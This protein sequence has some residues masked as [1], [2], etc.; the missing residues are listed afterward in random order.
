MAELITTA[1]FAALAGVRPSTVAYWRKRY[2]EDFPAE[3]DR[4]DAAHHRSVHYERSAVE[5][6]LARHGLRLEDAE[7]MPTRP[8]RRRVAVVETDPDLPR[9][10]DEDRFRHGAAA[11]ASTRFTVLLDI[12][13][14]IALADPTD[15]RERA[16]LASIARDAGDLRAK[17]PAE[18][19]DRSQQGAAV[20]EALDDLARLV[21]RHE[22]ASVRELL[23]NPGRWLQDAGTLIEIPV[24]RGPLNRM[25]AHATDPTAAARYFEQTCRSF[26]RSPSP[27]SRRP[28]DVA[29]ALTKL[30]PHLAPERPRTFVDLTCGIGAAAITAYRGGSKVLGF[31]RNVDDVRV[32][33]Q[34]AIIVERFGE[35]HGPSAVFEGREQLTE[36][37]FRPSDMVVLS[38]PSSDFGL[39][40]RRND[41]IDWDGLSRRVAFARRQLT[42]GGRV[43]LVLPTHLLDPGAVRGPDAELAEMARAEWVDGLEAVLEVPPLEMAL[44]TSILIFHP[45]GARPGDRRV[46]FASLPADHRNVAEVRELLSLVWNGGDLHDVRSPLVR[47]AALVPRGEVRRSGGFLAPGYWWRRDFA[48]QTPR[49]ARVL[50][51]DRDLLDEADQRLSH[52]LRKLGRIDVQAVTPAERQPHWRPLDELV[53]AG[54]LRTVVAPPRNRPIGRNRPIADDLRADATRPPGRDSGMPIVPLNRPVAD[55][56]L[57]QPAPP[58]RADEHVPLQSGDVVLW[59]EPSGSTAVRII[60]DADGVVLVA[61]GRA[62]RITDEGRRARLSPE[63]VA[64]AVEASGMAVERS[65]SRRPLGEFQFPS[66]APEQDVIAAIRWADRLFGEAAEAAATYREVELR[67]AELAARTSDLRR[68]ALLLAAS[69]ALEV[70]NRRPADD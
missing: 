24:E 16:L 44:A 1:E 5:D 34:W 51:A 4:P 9:S 56:P 45:E 6:F 35:R 33:R 49:A 65:A 19:R 54:L 46:L 36:V 58:I 28:L 10:S 43:L 27:W 60:G 21:R 32:A 53:R 59:Q 48:W 68:D 7:R 39:L 31:D 41:G 26:R 42:P 66:E 17:G 50:E 11:S 20:V 8:G 3:A 40:R 63:L 64:F 62:L 25:L 70:G 67:A 37:D 61:P 38:E 22:P 15:D 30:L 13:I 47:A 12:A 29:N 55:S 2:S 57:A 18:S 23:W 14:T 52:G 69:Q